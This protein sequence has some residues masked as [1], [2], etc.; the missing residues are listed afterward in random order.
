MTKAITLTDARNLYAKGLL[1]MM[2]DKR[3]HIVTL[4]DGVKVKIVRPRVGAIARAAYY[5]RSLRI[6]G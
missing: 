1:T 4:V 2:V 3:G 6:G 5:A